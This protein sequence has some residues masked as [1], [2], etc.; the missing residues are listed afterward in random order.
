[1][2]NGDYGH[3]D[4]NPRQWG[5]QEGTHKE[6]KVIGNKETGITS[7]S[8]ISHGLQHSD[9]EKMTNGG[10]KDVKPLKGGK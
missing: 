10:V 6:P 2:D 4:D 1:M 8:L 7:A 3:P 5:N 9:Y